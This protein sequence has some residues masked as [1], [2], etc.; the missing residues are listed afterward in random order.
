MKTIVI[1]ILLGLVLAL[2]SCVYQNLPPFP[3]SASIGG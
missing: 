3:T 1:L 2:G